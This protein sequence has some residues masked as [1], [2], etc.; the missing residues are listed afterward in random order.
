MAKTW[1][2]VKQ[3]TELFSKHKNC[4]G[5]LCLV[6]CIKYMLPQAKYASR[7]ETMDRV[8][9]LQPLVVFRQ[10]CKTNYVIERSFLCVDKCMYYILSPSQGGGKRG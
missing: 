7:E 10:T 6:F 8:Q 4:S 9:P 3:N 2:K 5:S 1:Q